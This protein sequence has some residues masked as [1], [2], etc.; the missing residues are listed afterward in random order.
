MSACGGGRDL[1]KRSFR[2]NALHRSIS[3]SFLVLSSAIQKTGIPSLVF[4]VVI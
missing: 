3:L 2:I 4:K 1:I